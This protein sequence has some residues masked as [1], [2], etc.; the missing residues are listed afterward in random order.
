[1]E[2]LDAKDQSQAQE[3]DEFRFFLETEAYLMEEGLEALKKAK[4]AR[5]KPC[6]IAP[7]LK[8][9]G[10]TDNDGHRLYHCVAYKPQVE[11]VLKACRKAGFV[12]REFR[13]N[14][15]EWSS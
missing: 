12:A 1:M 6:A 8:E 15:D 9:T 2:S 4:N 14:R 5:M 10:I 3:N 11:D 13:Y 7:F